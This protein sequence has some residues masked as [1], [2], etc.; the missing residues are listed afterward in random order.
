ML[1]LQNINDLLNSCNNELANYN[2]IIMKSND[3]QMNKVYMKHIQAI[4]KI[5]QSLQYYKNLETP[6]EAKKKY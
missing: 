1:S 6:E 4:L 3:K 2:S 5:I